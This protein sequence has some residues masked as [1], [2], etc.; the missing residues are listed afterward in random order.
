MGTGG[1]G[2]HGAARPIRP[3]LPLRDRN[4]FTQREAGGYVVVMVGGN[5]TCGGV[6]GV[7]G[8][9]HTE[10]LTPPPPSPPPPSRMNTWGEMGEMQGREEGESDGEGGGC[11]GRV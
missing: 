8:R 3:M 7:F 4:R 2:I 5:G 10:A 9:G 11:A 1:L 6:S